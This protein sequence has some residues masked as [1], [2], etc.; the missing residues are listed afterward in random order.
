MVG[1]RPSGL[2]FDL[3][4]CRAWSA[5][6]PRNTVPLPVWVGRP[7]SR[8]AKLLGLVIVVICN[9]NFNL[10]DLPLGWCEVGRGLDRAF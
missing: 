10:F 5:G 1:F 6:V 2:V 3:Q 4:H 7:G 9:F 8:L